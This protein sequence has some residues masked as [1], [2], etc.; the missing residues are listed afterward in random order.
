MNTEGVGVVLTCAGGW[1]VAEVSAVVCA[2]TVSAGLD[3]T[4]VVAAVL[5][6][7]AHGPALAQ[8]RQT[9]D[10]GK[11]QPSHPPPP[12]QPAIVPRAAPAHP[13]QLRPA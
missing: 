1:F 7:A 4:S 6:E 13:T 10:E 5:G 9:E 12:P 3:T 2:V 8:H 11:G